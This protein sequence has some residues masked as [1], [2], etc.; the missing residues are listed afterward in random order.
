[1]PRPLLL[2]ALATF[3]V[4]CSDS[5]TT[6]G[7]PPPT[8]GNVVAVSAGGN[9]TCAL[10]VD[11]KAFCWGRNTDGQLG[12]GT[13]EDRLN[14]TAVAGGLSF[15]EISAGEQHTCG[16]TTAS[17]VYCWGKN[18]QGQSGGSGT[19]DPVLA[20]ALAS[21]MTFTTVSA[22]VD[23]TCAISSGTAYCWGTGFLGDANTA[24]RR[25]N[26]VEVTG[27][28]WSVVS[29]GAN[30]TCALRATGS[31]YCWGNNTGG[32]LG[33]G[34]TTGSSVNPAAVVGGH[35]FVAIDAGL[36][37]TCGVGTDGTAYCW[38]TN[39][40][41]QL[42]NGA[43]GSPTGTPTAAPS[44]LTFTAVAAGAD[45]SCAA[46]SDGTYCWGANSAGQL[47]VTGSTVHPSP[48]KSDAQVESVS[49]F[50]HHTC[51]V[52]GNFDAWCWGA[53]EYGQVGN[54]RTDAAVAI[55]VKITLPA[56]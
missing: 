1:M 22:G 41:A 5:T 3:V 7:G 43:P 25:P 44:S 53:N 8:I 31:A 34:T 45:H 20:P 30:Y 29:A 17:Q 10:R 49:S 56:Q 54:G 35:T 55:P 32:L 38:G 23:H 46:F 50:R 14:P 36:N 42:G 24:E 4:S 2:I 40:N 33:I 39:A 9:H 47:G 52:S 48:T 21:T 19:G 13:Q 15:A 6:P 26:P 16:V 37:H 51:G 27:G 11:G 18:L 28:P 12:D